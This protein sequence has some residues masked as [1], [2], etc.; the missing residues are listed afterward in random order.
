[1]SRVKTIFL[2]FKPICLQITPYV[3]LCS[4][5]YELYVI[6]NLYN[7][8]FQDKECFMKKQKGYYLG[9]DIGTNSIGWAANFKCVIFLFLNKR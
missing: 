1:M 8:K 6:I 5:S 4:T 3:F 9:L 7:L 2:A